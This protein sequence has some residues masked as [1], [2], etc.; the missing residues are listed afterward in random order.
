MK[1]MC[2]ASGGLDSATMMLHLRELGHEIDAISFD[3]AQRHRKELEYGAAFCARYEIPRLVV[4]LRD[5][6]ALMAKG[7]GAL[8]DRN[9]PVPHGHYESESMKDTVVPGRNL[10]FASIAA[11]IAATNGFDAIALGVHAGDHAIYPDC[12]EEFITALGAI[13]VD[14]G[15]NVEIVTPFLDEDKRFIARRSME[16]GLDASLTWTC[17]E[18]GDEPCGK[19]GACVERAEAF[20]EAGYE[21][22]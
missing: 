13:V 18:G 21:R 7:A 5:V 16:L 2:I 10:M 9:T 20:K 12:R 19:C 8:L 1:V 22:S 15:A 14:G 3:Y 6:G 4:N 11:A 17:Y